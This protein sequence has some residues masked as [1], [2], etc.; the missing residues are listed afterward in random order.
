MVSGCND[1]HERDPPGISAARA[2]PSTPATL[3]LLFSCAHLSRLRWAS[4]TGRA[5]LNT[6]RTSAGGQGTGPGRASRDPRR[7]DRPAPRAGGA[8]VAVG[9]RSAAWLGP[10][11]TTETRAAPQGQAHSR[12]QHNVLRGA[13]AQ[14]VQTRRRPGVGGGRRA[15]PAQTSHPGPYRLRPVSEPHPRPRHRRTKN[16]SPT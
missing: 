10:G 6:D 15:L 16:R 4:I 11:V 5:I 3:L 2:W 1:P 13:C 12:H 8:F 9:P 14:H 7:R